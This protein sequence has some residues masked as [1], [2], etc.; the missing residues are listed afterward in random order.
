MA[1]NVNLPTT[2]NE[3]EHLIF[4]GLSMEYSRVACRGN[5]DVEHVT[6]HFRN[7]VFIYC[8]ADMS[9]AHPLDISI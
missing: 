9:N 3:A 1:S 6:L 4:R 8:C 5:T 2:K 7:Y